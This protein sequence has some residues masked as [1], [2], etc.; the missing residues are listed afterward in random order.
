VSLSANTRLFSAF[1]VA[2][3]R[4]SRKEAVPL[5]ENP[6]VK[7]R[8]ALFSAYLNR[9]IE[10]F[11]VILHFSILRRRSC[12]GV[13]DRSEVYCNTNRKFNQGKTAGRPD[14]NIPQNY[15]AKRAVGGP[16]CF[17]VSGEQCF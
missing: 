13:S 1:Y 7:I 17:A 16:A 12:F 9:L 11:S 8:N 15:T 6:S 14:A 5:L 10:K 3:L 4:R 2:L